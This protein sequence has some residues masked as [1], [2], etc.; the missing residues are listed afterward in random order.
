MSR[1][2]RACEACQKLKAKCDPSPSGRCERCERADIKCVPSAP[3]FQRDR[4]AE[5]EAQVD[6]LLLR[7]SSKTPSDRDT[8]SLVSFIDDRID[9]NAQRRV[10]ATFVSRNLQA[11]PVLSAADMDLDRLR[12]TSPH[13][14][15]AIMAFPGDTQLP[16]RAHEELVVRAMSAFADEVIARGNRSL[17]MVKA[18][19]TAAF[20]FRPARNTPH[21]HC[22]Q[23]VQLAMDMAVDIG[24]AGPQLARSPPAYF[25]QVNDP[26]SPDARR[27]WVACFL[28]ATAQSLCTRRPSTLAWTPYLQDCVHILDGADDLLAHTAR[29]VS[30][31]AE[32]AGRLD[33]CNT[34]AYRGVDETVEQMADLR[35]RV[36]ECRN[37]LP[38]DLSSHPV[39]CFWREVALVLV[40]E[41]ALHTPT[42]KVSFAAPYV[43]EKIAVTDFACPVGE[44]SVETARTLR[45]LVDACHAAVQ[46]FVD[47]DPAMML[48][49]A[50]LN[51]GPAVLYAHFVLTQVHVAVTGQGNM[52]GRILGPDDVALAVSTQKLEAVSRTLDRIDPYQTSFTTTLLQSARWMRTWLTD[53][54]AIVARYRETLARTQAGAVVGA[55]ASE[56]SSQR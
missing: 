7:A 33:L 32:A 8:D 42:N 38:A 5:L 15:L 20:W 44:P 9:L 4:I 10:L 34:T 52:L 21:G 14:L 37:R 29:I 18:L 25:S 11:W 51:V 46:R 35:G 22:Y 23:L 27:T 3:R 50:T 47:M 17:E 40:H 55:A 36:A 48:A 12:A 53:Y 49:V 13:L 41:V 28:A 2:P 45:H 43:P 56:S 31:C 16:L 39:L 54:D 24:I 19:L 1:R 30:L 6:D 26:T